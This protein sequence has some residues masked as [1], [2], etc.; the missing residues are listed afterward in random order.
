M[1]CTSIPVL[2]LLNAWLCTSFAKD[3]KIT[4]NEMTNEITQLR[5]EANYESFDTNRKIHELCPKKILALAPQKFDIKN[6]DLFQT[7]QKAKELMANIT[8]ERSV[9]LLLQK[10][11]HI[12]EKFHDIM[13][14]AAKM[15]DKDVEALSERRLVGLANLCYQYDKYKSLPDALLEEEEEEEGEAKALKD[16]V[17]ETELNLIHERLR[18]VNEDRVWVQK[19]C[20]D[21]LKDVMSR[22]PQIFTSDDISVNETEPLITKLKDEL[23][24]ANE[25]RERNKEELFKLPNTYQKLNKDL[26]M[27]A[28]VLEHYKSDLECYERLKAV[29]LKGAFTKK[30]GY[31]HL[32]ASASKLQPA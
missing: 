29:A 32:L 24:A 27:K 7:F 12:V 10:E 17:M 30:A 2:F 19:F 18:N 4:L 16:K 9:T 22:I 31:K 6:T 11:I 20:N 13:T 3:L 26:Q 21:Q 28:Y 8:R 15:M 1:T 14:F 5:T 25:I 23:H